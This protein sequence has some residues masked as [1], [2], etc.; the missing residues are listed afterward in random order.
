PNSGR[1]LGH[2]SPGAG[3]ARNA[4]APQ[5]APRE[6]AGAGAGMVRETGRGGGGVGQGADRARA[7]PPQRSQALRRE[8]GRDPR[9]QDHRQA[10]IRV[11]VVGGQELQPQVEPLRG[12]V[13]TLHAGRVERDEAGGLRRGAGRRTGGLGLRVRPAGQFR[14]AAAVLRGAKPAIETMPARWPDRKR[15][16]LV[17]VLGYAAFLRLYRIQSVPPGLYRDEAMDGNN[18]I[19]VL[20]TRR[21]QVFYPE[22]GG[23][24]GLYINVAALF[25]ARIGH[26]AWVL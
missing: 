12:A 23:R 2:G 24:E 4:D 25:V 3:G 1:G 20:E 15:L 6:R 21:W 16:V 10:G 8:P 26:E 22:D 5:L 14:R 17:F 9:W 11:V 13:R 7:V 18:A 19:E